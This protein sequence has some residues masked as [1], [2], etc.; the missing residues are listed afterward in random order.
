MKKG[1]SKILKTIIITILI[2]TIFISSSITIAKIEFL[3]GQID[4]NLPG[5]IYQW[6]NGYFNGEWNNPDTSMSGYLYGYLKQGR[7]PVIGQFIASITNSDQ[8]L[9]FH[10]KGF[11]IK[12]IIVGY[13]TNTDFTNTNYF[14]GT[15]NYDESSFTSKIKTNLFGNI[16][17]NGTHFDSFLPM[18]TGMYNVGVEAFHLI[19]YNRL[20][21]FTPDDPDDYREIMIQIWYPTEENLT[22]K[23]IEYMDQ[24]T[25][26][27]LF[28]RSPV[29]LITIPK[30][31]FKFVRPY[32]L[33]N[34]SISISNSI[35]PVIIFSPGYD[36]VYQIYTSLI[37]DVVSHGFIVVS[38]NHPYISGVTVFPDGRSV[39][40]SPDPPGDLA[41]RTVVDDAKFVLDTLYNMNL[42]DGKFAGHLDLSNVGMYGHSFGGAAT[43]IC[44]FEDDRFKV[45]LTLDGVIYTDYINGEINKPFLMMNAENRFSNETIDKFL[46]DHLSNDAYQIT[47]NGSTH[48]GYTDIGI[49]LNHFVP[50][51]PASILG[52][53][54]INAKRLVNITKSYELA[55]FET[56]LKNM[57][58]ES[59]FN[60]SKI[61]SEVVFKYK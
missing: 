7:N 51:I 35:F 31:A 21:E 52:F 46:W 37:E 17:C 9:V 24:T 41:I 34:P 18:L 22:G 25:F 6:A 8:L 4:H 59:M 47:V 32:S 55:F 27:W 14:Y 44:C 39:G 5:D 29:P 16:V 1:N 2:G 61:F 30:N 38:I 3:K 11:F 60:L 10:I 54:S 36:G 45:G 57:P 28:G 26:N 58:K 13:F 19:D 40:L 20:E 15:F 49:L 56:Y 53:G 42:S 12:N 33:D 50:L 48:F 43:T 23:R